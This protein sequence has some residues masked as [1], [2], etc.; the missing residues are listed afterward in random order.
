MRIIGSRLDFGDNTKQ[1]NYIAKEMIKDWIKSNYNVEYMK[2]II[3]L[4]MIII[5]CKFQKQYVFFIFLQIYYVVYKK[6][7]GFVP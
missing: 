3:I 1:P 2:I 5:L 4:I 6:N 7:Y